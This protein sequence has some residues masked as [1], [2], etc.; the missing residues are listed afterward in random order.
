[1]TIFMNFV[2]TFSFTLTSSVTFTTHN[3]SVPSSLMNDEVLYIKFPD[4]SLFNN[5]YNE[6]LVWKQ[7]TFDK[8]LVED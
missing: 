2:Y 1:M 3:T 5:D 7:K 6:Y 4:L 8:L